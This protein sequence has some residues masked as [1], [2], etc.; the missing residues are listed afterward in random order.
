MG[1]SN[2][3]EL[4]QRIE[5]TRRSKVITY[6]CSDR[7][8]ASAQIAGDMIRPMYDHLRSIGRRRR[9][10]LFLYSRGGDVEVPWRVITMLREYTDN[11]GVL[12]PFNAH[13]AATMIAL[14]CDE[15]VMGPKAEL[16]P[17]DPATTL[18][19]FEGG[20]RHQDIIRV[21]D[22]MSY[23]D[24]L[25][26]KA[27]LGDQQAI[28]SNISILTEKLTP[29][30]VGNI[31]RT[32]S[33]IRLVARKLLTSHKQRLD[34][35]R[36]NLIVETLAEKLF[37]HGHGI[38]RT[39]AREIGLPVVYPTR[40]LEQLMWALLEDYE[41]VMNMRVPINAEDIL[42]RDRDRAEVQVDL[43]M[44]ESSAMNWSFESILRLN[45]IRQTPGEYKI[46][47]NFGVSLPEGIAEE[48]IPAAI[49][50]QLAQQMQ[51]GLQDMVRKQVSEQSPV[52]RVEAQVLSG[53][54]KDTTSDGR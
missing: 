32:H 10:D 11:L 53:A 41:N 34:D 37:Q 26:D 17:I 13:S 24:F 54:W 16:G 7:Q 35:Q 30:H 19:R 28:A 9:I 23:V 44:T 1:R 4:I 50:Q 51:V 40:R 25:R 52:I 20:V 49:L 14:G 39:E 38:T 5:R 46:N 33:H 15:V 6:V 12:I 22:V 48:Q 3:L 8:G 42:G 27:G 45:R 36:I 43:A 47:I 21:E 31:Y 18:Q 29:W 2:R